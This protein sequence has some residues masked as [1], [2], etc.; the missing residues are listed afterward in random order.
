MYDKI[1]TKG[2]IN[3]CELKN[4][5]ILAPMD[6]S[7]G[8]ATGEMSPRG[9]EYYAAKAKGGC[10][11]VIV[12][13]IAVCGPEL[14]GICITGQTHLRSLADRHAMGNLA[15]RVHEYG[16][17]V[18]AQLNHPGRKTTAKYNDGNEPV[19]C[20][21]IT[22][23]MEGRFSPARELTHDEIQQ[24]IACYATAG[25]HA[26]L[27]GVDGVEIH[28]AHSYLLNQ[29]ISAAKN[30]RTD[31]YGGS[32]ENRCRIIVEIIQAIREKVPPT[33]PITIR[34]NAF[35]GENLEGE[36]TLEDTIEISKYLEKHGVDAI[37]YTLGTVDRTGAPELE[38]GWRNEYYK[39]IKKEISVPIYGPNE[40]K[41]PE[42]GEAI[43][44]EGVYDFLVMG[45]QQSAD[46]EWGNKARAGRSED[47]RPCISCNY[48]LYHVTAE[49]SQIR[50]A[51]NPLLGRE[52]DNLAPLNKGEGTVVIIG[53]GP[54]GI[55]AAITSA[56]RGFDVILIDKG[57]EVGGALQLANKPPKKFR[58]DRLVEYYAT[59]INKRDNIDLRLNTEVTDEM[60][61]D[62]KAMNPYA[63]ILAAGGKPIVPRFKGVEKAV[64]ANDVLCGDITLE[65]KKVVVVGGGM[66]G[67][68]T[69]SLLAVNNDVTVLEMMPMVGNGIFINNVI[70]TIEHLSDLGTV[71][72]TST[73][74]KEIKDGAV[75]VE[76]FAGKANESVLT[77]IKNIV[78]HNPFETEGEEKHDGPYDIPCDMVV[79]SIGVFSDNELLPKL[80]ATFDNVL[81]IGDSY[82]PGKIT[83]A[84]TEGYFTAKNL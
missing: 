59:Q 77:G 54:A 21:S 32:M 37:H 66:T 8:T 30:N 55:E 65:N 12:G 53:A 52:I 83:T 47:I 2:R 10:G 29:F 74:L 34:L 1:F 7:L 35:D 28:C 19:S 33:Y 24:L 72:K 9:I 49:E 25:E 5:I 20:S 42:E 60:L 51:V 81:N 18:F 44:E 56:D 31:E 50:C 84:T 73:A 17:K 61:E 41:T 80:E 62:L 75:T 64:T 22:P 67:L 69:A 26:F 76:P 82:K 78:G 46:P 70:K 36:N 48:C 45:R 38:A 57:S 16:G 58:I 4:R 15:E 40:V 63:V 79:L 11:L 6:D 13:Y 43:M 27:A 23:Q 68:E 71:L 39:Q 14:S 3:G